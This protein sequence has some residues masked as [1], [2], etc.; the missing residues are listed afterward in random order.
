ME[1]LRQGGVATH[2]GHAGPVSRKYASPFA[3][4]PELL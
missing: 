4:L 1:T 2:K 3:A